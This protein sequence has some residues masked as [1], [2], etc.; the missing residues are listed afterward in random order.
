MIFDEYHDLL[1]ENG[2]INFTF[3]FLNSQAERGH[4]NF[5]SKS[6][7]I[8]FR[9]SNYQAALLEPLVDMKHIF[10]MLYYD[11]L[12]EISIESGFSKIHHSLLILPIVKY[13]YQKTFL[14]F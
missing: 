3:Q 6:K 7:T 9:M 4:D 12:I 5:I 14:V 8:D 1:L 11:F 10:H 13:I 2:K